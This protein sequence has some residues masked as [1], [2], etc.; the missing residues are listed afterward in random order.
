MNRP[1]LNKE[2]L[3]ILPLEK[4]ETLPSDFYTDEEFFIF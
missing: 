1:Y 4:S 3:K 2:D